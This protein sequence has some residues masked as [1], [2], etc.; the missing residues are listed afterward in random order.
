MKRIYIM[1]HTSRDLIFDVYKS[2]LN[3][4][5]DIVESEDSDV[6]DIFSLVKDVGYKYDDNDKKNC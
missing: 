2:V 6:V 1:Q 5:G 3:E 4:A